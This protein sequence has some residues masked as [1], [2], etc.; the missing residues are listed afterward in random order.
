MPPSPAGLRWIRGPAGLE[1]GHLLQLKLCVVIGAGGHAR[2]LLDALRAADAAARY[3]LLDADPGRTGGK[4]DGID[5]LGTDALLPALAREE[6]VRFVVGVG[7]VGDNHARLRLFDQALSCGIAPLTVRHPAAIISPAAI[8]AEGSQ[9]LAGSIVNPGAVVGA[10]AI[11][12]TCAVIEHDCVVG[13]HAH[14]ATGARLSGSVRVGRGAHVGA[15]ATIKQGVSLGDWSVVGVGAAV[16]KD[17]APRMLV[18]G[19]PARVV[20]TVGY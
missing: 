16:V 13:D 14:I 5:I 4:L 6:L 10:N 8:V 11:V 9:L 3:V 12:N 20:R 18:T 7:S 2:V 1:D 17:V 15:G 19:V